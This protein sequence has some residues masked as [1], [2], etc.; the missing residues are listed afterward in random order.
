MKPPILVRR[1]PVLVFKSKRGAARLE[2]RFESKRR[3]VARAGPSDLRDRIQARSPKMTPHTLD[4]SPETLRFAHGDTALGAILVAESGKGVVA[5]FFGDD[6]AKLMRDLEQAFPGV[7]LMED[8]DGLARTVAKAAAL[9][10]APQHGT[11]LQLDLRGSEL[12]LAVWRTLQA[13]PAGET[14]SYGAVARALPLAATA[15]E[16]GSACAANRI[17]VAVPCHRVVKADGA[18][19]G[20]RWGV[21]RK[22]RLIDLEGAA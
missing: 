17:A 11:D 18:I 1:T 7:R 9:V 2:S 16:V 15:Q 5:L 14:R 4:P 3:S 6:R 19:S 13:I 10:D 20:Y 21:Q 8:Q 22:R 12:E